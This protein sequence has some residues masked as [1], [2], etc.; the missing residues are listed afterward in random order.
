MAHPTT[1][2]R[3]LTEEVDAFFRVEPDLI[4]D[5]YPLYKRIRDE[6]PVL[7]THDRVLVSTYKDVRETLTSPL[8][9][10]GL[11][12]RGTRFRNASAQAAEEERVKLAE[13]FGFLE[14][15]LGGT[16][17]DHHTRLRRLAQKVFTPRMV[18]RMEARIEAI[19]NG[20][21]DDI[22]AEDEVEFIDA[23]SF[24]L[25]LMVISE[26]LDIS[27]DDREH[28]RLWA[29]QLGHFVG[30]DWTDTSIIDRTHDSV[31]NLRR[32]LTGVF[33][34]R[35]GGDTTDLLS[36]LIAAEAGGD[37]FTE[38]ELVAMITQLIFAG[39][40]TSTMFLGNSLVRLLDEYREQWDRLCA[41]P[42]LIPV[43]VEELLRFESPT[44]NIDKLAAEDFEIGGVEVKQW[45]TINV[46]IASANHDEEVFSNAEHLDLQ[47]KYIPHVTFGFG[48][49]YCLGAALARL[50]AQVSLRTLTRRFP[51]MRLTTDTI[52]WR[53][54]HM[55]RGPLVLPV[56]LGGEAA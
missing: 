16:N 43:A 34:A 54:T 24:H 20:L 1:L 31:F 49:H 12:V 39:H 5:P 53:P 25:P 38:D 32:Y 55:N 8:V 42:A 10:Q 9:L 13:M 3:P 4:A 50:E 26:M 2:S 18:S 14:K 27:T 23:Y 11:A 7:R 35:R 46:M 47:R 33:D 19:A 52:Q 28:L 29:N 51:N 22:A 56:K 45:D 36:A 6:A 44:H 21:L 15:R 48:A 17:G 41:D 30:A 37:R 40:E